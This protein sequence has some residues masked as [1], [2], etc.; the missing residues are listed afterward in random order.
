MDLCSTQLF[1]DGSFIRNS[2]VGA[3][4]KMTMHTTLIETEVKFTFIRSP[5]PG[6][7]NVNKTATAAELRF[8]ALHSPLLSEGV[9]QRLI[10][11][12]GHLM[13]SRGELIIKATRYRTQERNKQD[14][15]RRLKLL[16]LQATIVPKRRK[17]TKPTVAAIERRLTEK[18]IHA[19]RKY[20]RRQKLQLD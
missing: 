13:T 8:D 16:L 9:R 10:K 19:R 2:V 11:L 12:A 5:G 17:K 15:L 18:K 6:G 3:F 7:Q 4:N 20:I 14:A 1:T